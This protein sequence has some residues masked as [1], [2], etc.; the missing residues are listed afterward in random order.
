MLK[1]ACGDA[2]LNTKK[3]NNSK[4]PLPWNEETSVAYDKV[5]ASVANCPKLYFLEEDERI[6]P[7]FLQTDASEYGYGAYLF[8]KLYGTDERPVAFCS[9][10]FTGAQMRWQVNEKEAFG[11]Y[12]AIIHFEYLLRDKKFTLQTDHQNL[13]Y[14]SDSCS[15]KV[16]RWKI[17]IMEFNFDCEHIKGVDNSVADYFSRLKPRTTDEVVM[18]CYSPT[19]PTIDQQQFIEMCHAM[20]WAPALELGTLATSSNREY[21]ARMALLEPIPMVIPDQV[22]TEAEAHKQPTINLH[23]HDPVNSIPKRKK[24]KKSVTIQEPI[25]TLPS[26][27]TTDNTNPLMET[28]TDA[29]INTTTDIPTTVNSPYLHETVLAGDAAVRDIRQMYDDFKTV[30]GA[31][32]GHH[33]VERTLTK[34]IEYLKSINR[35]P[36]AG[37]RSDVQRFVRQCPCCQKMSQ[38]KPVVATKPYTLAS[39]NPWEKIN[40]DAMGPFPETPEG[41]KHIIV[42]VDCFTRF[43]ELLPA[44]STGAHDAKRAILSVIGRYGAPHSITT[45]SGSQFKNN[46]IHEVIE[47]LGI[48]HHFT[49]AYSKEEN[50][51]VER[52]NKEVLRH[53]AAMIYETRITDDWIDFLPLIQRIINSTVHSSIGVAP[54]QLLF[55]DSIQL[56][57][58]VFLPIQKLDNSTPT[59]KDLATWMDKML[60]KQ[61]K[62]MAMAQELQRRNDKL[63][64]TRRDKQNYTEFPINSYVLVAYPHTRMGQRPPIK[65]MTPYRG[66]MRV[67]LCHDSTYLIQDLVTQKTEQVHV[68]LLKKFEYDPT[69]VDPVE[70]AMHDTKEYVVE[71]ILGHTGSFDD[72][73]TLKFQVRWKG[74]GPQDDTFEPWDNVKHNIYLHEY[75]RRNK[76]AR[77]IPK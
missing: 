74:Y 23:D 39:Y 28:T 47:K 12:H 4:K 75:L 21:L 11:I 6:H 56:D 32:P 77:Y 44:T 19:E 66:P 2:N 54:A 41:Y 35:Q 20:V 37:I 15:H 60:T 8:Q 22:N 73:S 38:L 68:S 57:R 7:I 59:D 9:K 46:T 49:I 5:I 18:M 58:G 71:S 16:I 70:V 24:R 50:A 51:M 69:L 14:I 33:G 27:T 3:G 26:T 17:A 25:T 43:V 45:D 13:T 34:L 52:A 76:L 72:K 63:N 10:T 40:I 67:I 30:H 61:R 65:T 62:I 55:G 31:L 48:Y 36:W 42:I 53:L 64:Y 29:P 1:A